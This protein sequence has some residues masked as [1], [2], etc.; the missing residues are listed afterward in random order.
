MPHGGKQ[1]MPPP[2]TRTSPV[3]TRCQSRVYA[4][5]RPAG[6]TLTQMEPVSTLPYTNDVTAER[7]GMST[8][9]VRVAED[10]QLQANPVQPA[11]AVAAAAAAVGQGDVDVD[12]DARGGGANDAA[13]WRSFGRHREGD[14]VH[15]SR[16]GT[17]G[18]RGGA[19]TDP[20]AGRVGCRRHP[21]WYD[22]MVLTDRPPRRPVGPHTRILATPAQRRRQRVRPWRWRPRKGRT[23]TG[24]GEARRG[25]SAAVTAG[26][27]GGGA[28]RP[29]RPAPSH[30]RRLGWRSKGGTP[31]ARPGRDR[32]GR[33]AGTRRSPAGGSHGT[34]PRRRRACPAPR[35]HRRRPRRPSAAATAAVATPT[36]VSADREGVRGGGRGTGGV[37]GACAGGGRGPAR[38]ARR[39]RRRR[40]RR[41]PARPPAGA[42]VQRW[43]R[44]P[45]RRPAVT[46]AAGR[47]AARAAAHGRCAAAD[48]RRA[49]R[50][51]PFRAARPA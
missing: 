7:G 27:D 40:R 36:A 38:P 41:H 11:L 46:A 5:S 19:R 9:L 17:G 15:A 18:P 44:L 8:K 3:R 10:G 25:G 43:R 1:L 12:L 13:A 37:G 49:G 48:G 34:A 42:A 47:H 6:A 16:V 26:G 39:G 23:A 32:S 45:A 14:D 30:P 24:R 22:Q 21:P 51:C 20:V 35:R 33:A 4:P 28:A 31:D 2:P 50:R 29:P